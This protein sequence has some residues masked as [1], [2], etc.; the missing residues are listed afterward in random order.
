MKLKHA[1]IQVKNLESS[2]RFY[3]DL[4]GLKP[5]WKLDPDWTLLKD[6]S[7][8]MLALIQKGHKR[9]RPH[10]GFLVD[11]KKQVD[12]IHKKIG[13]TSLQASPPEGHRDGSYG[14]YF[15]DPDGNNVE[16]LYFPSKRT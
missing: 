6:A 16:I 10:I 13:K 4:L 8:G 11:S 14:F 7:G 5:A 1:G 12:S 2:A 3:R 15:K 9:H